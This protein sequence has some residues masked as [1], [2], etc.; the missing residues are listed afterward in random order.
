MTWALVTGASKGLG[1]S[2]ALMLAQEGY[3]LILH[4]YKDSLS[5]EETKDQV[6]KW[7]VKATILQADFNDISQVKAFALK[8][9][10]NFSP[11]QVVLHNVGPYQAKPYADV[12]DA[13]FQDALNG[14]LRAPFT[15]IKALLHRLKKAQGSFISIGVVGLEKCFTKIDHPLYLLTKNGLL[16]MMRA[17]AKEY[18]GVI[19]FNMIS[20]GHLSYSVNNAQNI[21]TT[22]A[23]IA[24]TARFLISE[25][26]QQI[27]GQNIEVADGFGI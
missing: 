19:R 7:G 4:F 1:R 22:N 11:L 18:A 14:G 9:S 16:Q 24:D 23:S 25:K 27:T 17:F 21:Y 10:E 2:L 26:G 15:L 20:P 3:D 5:I 6:L 13:E 8:I 12:N